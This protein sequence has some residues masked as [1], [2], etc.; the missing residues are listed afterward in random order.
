MTL[1][2]LRDVIS[3]A[4]VLGVA[5][6]RSVDL[7]KQVKDRE[8]ELLVRIDQIKTKINQPNKQE[9]LMPPDPRQAMVALRISD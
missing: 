5:G 8:F 3:G 7:E 2:R 1:S 4:M 6:N 9:D